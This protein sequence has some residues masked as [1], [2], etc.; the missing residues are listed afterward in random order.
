MPKNLR[1]GSGHKKGKNKTHDGRKD[2]ALVVAEDGQ[3]YGIVKNR[4]GGRRVSVQCSDSMLRSALIPGQFIK[5]EWIN[6]DDIL[7]CDPDM[8]DASRCYVRI[9]YTYQESLVLKNMGIINFDIKDTEN[10][11]DYSNDNND[12]SNSDD[13]SDSCS[14]NDEIIHH[15][16]INDIKGTTLDDL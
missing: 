12:D 16:E 11:V 14:D 7:L 5:R 4:L 1:G 3:F 2:R 8:S 13:E 6:K 15:I 10:V 9:K